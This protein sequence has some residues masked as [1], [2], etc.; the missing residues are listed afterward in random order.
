MKTRMLTRRLLH[1]VMVLLLSAVP[2]TRPLADT[3]DTFH[4]DASNADTAAHWAARSTLANAVMFSGL[5]EPL[6]LSMSTMDD[7]LKHAGYVT[8]PPMPNMALVGTVYAGGSPRYPRT[9]DFAKPATLVWDAA[10]FD[11]TLDPAAHAWTLVKITSPNFHL[12]FHDRKEDRRAALVMLPQAKAQADTLWKRLRNKDGLF[13]A[14]APDGM[15]AAPEPVDQAAVLWGV[16]NLIL[17]ATSEADDYWHTAYRDLIDPD[18]YRA[19]ASS[20]LA[21]LRKLPP[22]DAQ[23][24]AIAIAALGRYALAANTQDTRRQ[25]LALA[26]DHANALRASTPEALEAVAFAIYGLIEAGRLAGEQTYGEAASRLFRNRLLP[27]WSE[28]PGVFL[29]RANAGT[30]TYTPERTGAIVAALNAIRWYGAEGAASQAAAIYPRFF[31]TVLIRG[32][33]LQSSPAPLVPAVYQEKEPAAHFAHPALPAPAEAGVSP[34]FASGIT[35]DDGS[36]TVT[37][38]M[39]RTGPAL[40]LSN[41]LVKRHEGEADAFLPEQRLHD[42]R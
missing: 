28:Q 14:R 23:A 26:R 33:L 24:R 9:P 12:L 25:A 1:G 32:R 19:L 13:A 8:R 29:A 5:G 11:S 21:A 4:Y 40:F 18:D 20:A 15:Y 36:W 7:L 30:A 42:L 17:A 6:R 41:M 35:V 27:L 16:S 22:Q 31:E 37:D 2:C 38:P 34:V 3:H 39:F 10:S